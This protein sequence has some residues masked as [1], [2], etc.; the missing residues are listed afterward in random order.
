M[1]AEEK[2]FHRIEM[3]SKYWLRTKCTKED[4]MTRALRIGV[5][6]QTANEYV[7]AVILRH[8]EEWNKK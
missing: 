7:N 3:L 4:L 8:F 1:K 6:R 2:R 5:T